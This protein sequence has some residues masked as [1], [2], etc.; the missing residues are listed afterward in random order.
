MLPPYP[1]WNAEGF[2][3]VPF[4]PATVSCAGYAVDHYR[5]IYG[6][7]SPSLIGR[8][9]SVTLN[10]RRMYVVRSKVSCNGA[11]EDEDGLF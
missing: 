7:F 11:D 1:L 5:L 8:Y 3:S 10:I 6:R 9:P 4:P 2:S